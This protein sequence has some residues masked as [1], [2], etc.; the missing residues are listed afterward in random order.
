MNPTPSLNDKYVWI[1]EVSDNVAPGLDSM[2]TH[3]QSKYET[4]TA[5]QDTI[6]NISNTIRA[7]INNIQNEIHI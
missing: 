7:E 4:L 2:I 3:T 1:P 6:T 5:L